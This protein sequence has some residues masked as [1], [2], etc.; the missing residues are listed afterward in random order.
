MT[1]IQ[2]ATLAFRITILS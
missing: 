2:L 1:L